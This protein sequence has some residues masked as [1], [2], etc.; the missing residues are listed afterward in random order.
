MA[1]FLTREEPA[2]AQGG[3]RCV[4]R[5]PVSSSAGDGAPSSPLSRLVQDGYVGMP[6]G[7][8]PP[9]R[10]SE[11]GFDVGVDMPARSRNAPQN[12]A[13]DGY[14]GMPTASQ[15]PRRPSEGGF[16]AGIAQNRSNSS[17][18]PPVDKQQWR[19]E[20]D[21]NF[22]QHMQR[23]KHNGCRVS[24]AV[25]GNSSLSL[26]WD[27]SRVNEQQAP[28]RGRGVGEWAPEARPVAAASWPSDARESPAHQAPAP[29]ARAPSR[30]SLGDAAYRR[31][32]PGFGPQSGSWLPTGRID[33][34]V[35]QPLADLPSRAAP[36]AP[37]A[38]A[39]WY[40]GALPGMRGAHHSEQVSA[41]CFAQGSDQNCGN[42]LTGK[43][44]SRVSA[45][46]GGRSSFSFGDM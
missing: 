36:Q 25:G 9:R 32:P 44:T 17:G 40:C 29:G 18:P 12:L 10:P 6:A 11:G 38:P 33:S 16:D 30:E 26:G 15:I 13:Q 20:Q 4:Q 34:E 1:F 45:P 19:Q 2:K 21:P 27:D 42:V 23:N 39:D 43:P 37:A 7:G 3:K 8:R 35:S 22:L 41:N 24:Q 31:S 14:I 28:R 46:P 5:P